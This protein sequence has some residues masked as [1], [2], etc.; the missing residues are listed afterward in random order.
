VLADG[1]VV[2]PIML[3]AGRARRVAMAVDTGYG[4]HKDR[5]PTH[6]Y[7]PTRDTAAFAKSWRR[8]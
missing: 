5:T 2:G 8:A 7:E 3:A 6:S 4:H 1:G